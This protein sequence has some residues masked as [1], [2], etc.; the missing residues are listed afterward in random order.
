MYNVNEIY[1]VPNVGMFVACYSDKWDKMEKKDIEKEVSLIKEIPFNDVTIPVLDYSVDI[2]FVGGKAVTFKV[3]D[4]P[5]FLKLA[6]PF[7]V[8]Q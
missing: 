2:P 1:T 5:D 7:A 6:V 3:K 8:K 4:N